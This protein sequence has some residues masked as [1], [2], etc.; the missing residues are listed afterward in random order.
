M[1]ISQSEDIL[2]TSRRIASRSDPT[3]APILTVGYTVPIAAQ[4]TP[5]MISQ[6]AIVANQFQFSF[7]AES[8]RTYAV[9]FRA[10]LDTGNWL[11]LTNIPARLSATI[12]TVDDAI[13]P[14]NRWYRIRTP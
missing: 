7:D 5:P 10:A 9:E 14:D 11:T 6:L 13:G 3:N 2:L 12:I 8:N 1:L 4:P